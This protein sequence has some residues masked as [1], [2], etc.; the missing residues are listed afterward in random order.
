[1]GWPAGHRRRM[2]ALVASALA[3]LALV[4]VGCGSAPEGGV[5][6]LIVDG[7]IGP[8][9]ANYLERGIDDAEEG[10][11]EA[12][13]VLL[14]T[15]GGLDSSMRDMIQRINASTVPVVVYV[16]PAGARAASAGTFI[17]MAAHVAA[18]APDTA[19]GAAHP[20][21]A[22]GGDIQGTME[23]KVVNDAA[24]YARA[25]AQARGRNADWAERAVRE[26]V[27]ASASEAVELEVV[28]LQAS[29]LTALLAEVDGREVTLQ[30]GAT[31][32]LATA[33]AV[34][35]ENGMTF[36]E[37][38]LQVISDPNL[39]FLLLTVGSLALVVEVFNPTGIG[40]SIGILALVIAF[41]SLGTLP[42][43][44]AGAAL[45]LLGAALLAVEVFVVS[46]GVVGAAGIAVMMLGGLFLTSSSHPEFEVSRWLVVGLPATLGALLLALLFLV[47]RDRR[48]QPDVGPY[49]L[50]GM[51]GV[52]DTPVTAVDG[53]V[54]VRGERWVARLSQGFEGR[55]VA[56]GEPVVVTRFEGMELTVRPEHDHPPA[57]AQ[58][59]E[60]PRR[61]EAPR[62]AEGT[63]PSPD[64]S[65]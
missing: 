39:A 20:V 8:V 4:L 49:A 24:A 53:W 38:F 26:S 48:R 6:V 36:T 35:H 3:V 19:I 54:T 51:S 13:V 17:T 43:N 41:F 34:V 44:W 5:H 30:G 25:I 52:A 64:P 56:P 47:I 57:A 1:M 55:T 33:E 21:A 42:V 32:A 37:R 46:G 23:T 45:V 65:T 27:S 15:P 11:A 29:T 28:D 63:P 61:V 58:P 10:G 18:M 40:A 16:A 2:R 62:S 7:V 12:V 60:D 22:G 59:A 9:T 50:V 31:V 14:D